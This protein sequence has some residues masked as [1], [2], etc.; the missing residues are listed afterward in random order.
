MKKRDN[1]AWQR[2]SLISMQKYKEKG[3]CWQE[4]NPHL[5]LY[6]YGAEVAPFIVSLRQLLSC[7]FHWGPPGWMS[8]CLLYSLMSEQIS[9]MQWLQSTPWLSHRKPSILSIQGNNNKVK[10]ALCVTRS[11]TRGAVIFRVKYGKAQC[12]WGVACPWQ[13]KGRRMQL[14]LFCRQTRQHFQCYL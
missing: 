2:L 1:E 8:T 14:E 9:P 13:M 5:P 6:G 3:G 4:P 7:M 10:G 11:D 12:H